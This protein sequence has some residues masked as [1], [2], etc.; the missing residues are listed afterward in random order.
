[1][2]RVGHWVRRAALSALAGGGLTAAGVGGSLAGAQAAEAPTGSAPDAQPPTSLSPPQERGE[3]STSTTTTGTGTAT[4]PAPAAPAPSAPSGSGSAQQQTTTTSATSSPQPP[5]PSTRKAPKT[6]TPKGFRQHRQPS[7]V[8]RHGHTAEP[9]ASKPGGTPKPGMPSTPSSGS[10]TSGNIAPAPGLLASGALAPSPLLSG[11]LASMQALSF[12]RIPLFLLPIYKAASAQYGVPWQVLAAINEVETDYG[13]DLSVSTAGA[14]GWMQFM[15]ETW[16]QYGVDAVNAGYAD[17]YNPVDAIFAAARYL[18]AA[19]ASSDL[20]AAILAY[21]HSQAYVQS[22][23]LR[24]RLISSYPS[25][26]IATLTGLTEGSLPVPG[27]KLLAVPRVL[28]QAPGGAAQAGGPGGAEQATG[29]PQPSSTSSL[30]GSTPAP[31]PASTAAVAQQRADAPTPTSQLSDLSAPRDAPVLAVEDGRIVALGRSRSLGDYVV[32]RDTYGDVFTYASLGS[33]APSF[34]LPKPVE[35][36][37]PKGALRGAGGPEPAPKQA[38]TAGRQAP[39][40]LHVAARTLPGLAAGT[41]GGT[42]SVPP[43]QPGAGKVRVFAHPGNRDARA[44][45]KARAGRTRRAPIGSEALKRG[46]VVAQGTVIGH[47]GAVGTGH[48]RA[49]LRFA[50]RPAGAQQAVDP[51]PVLR[52]WAQLDAALHPQGAK[53]AGD[54]LAG[55]TAADAFAMPAAQLERAV[56]SDPG[57][58]L[59]ACDR[60]QVASGKV[61]ERMLALLVFMSRSGLEPT[62]EQLRC[63]H[64]SHRGGAAVVS[65]LPR[66]SLTIGA[67]NGVPIA[68]HQGPGSITDVAIRTLL[69]VEHPFAPAQIVSLMQY[70]GIAATLAR[71]D[72]AGQIEIVLPAKPSTHRSVRLARTAS[73]PANTVL[74]SAQ[75]DRLIAQIGSLAS[76]TVARKPS[77]AAVRD[78]RPG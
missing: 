52:N 45:A 77:S 39:L 47:L 18:H 69:T 29:K 26:V 37:V 42:G 73:A 14:V 22:V 33:I 1:V 24:A 21:N 27:A 62:V 7:T 50:V 8:V 41:V 30:P 56:L 5:K 36:T 61:D 44:A 59:G 43:T 53:A 49:M 35:L 40:T 9:T 76:P 34:R 11:S 3:H 78:R 74:D 4:T 46:A 23:M 48:S 70:P 51:G 19:G 17:P 38:A 13:N 31:S 6:S 75:W 12:Y 64:L 20:P 66:G 15:P 63:G 65:Y 28:L 32:L 71:P 2:S 10:T 16:L 58:R 68:G 54:V 60:Q 55:A 67:I 72:H 25:S 57:I